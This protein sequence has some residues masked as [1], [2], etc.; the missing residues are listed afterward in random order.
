MGNRDDLEVYRREFEKA[1]KAVKD[2]GDLMGV[3]QAKIAAEEHSQP[4]PMVT[5]ATQ[6]I[7]TDRKHLKKG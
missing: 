4:T 5:D 1:E 2:W 3:T 6:G 7:G